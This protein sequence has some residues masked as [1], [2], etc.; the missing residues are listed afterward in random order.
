MKNSN[1]I[2]NNAEVNPEEPEL[3]EEISY[4]IKKELKESNQGWTTKQVE[5]L[6]VKKSGIKYHYSHIYR[7]LRKWGFR[8][9]VPRKVHVNTATTEEKNDFKKRPNRYLWKITPK[10]QKKEKALP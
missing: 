7:I 6:I 2:N 5:E 4:R 3:S 9:K 8:Q 1:S 10:N